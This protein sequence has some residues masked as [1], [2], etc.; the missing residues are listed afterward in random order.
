MRS[1]FDNHSGL[2]QVLKEFP[3][4]L[5]SRPKLPFAQR[6]SRETQNAVVA[7]LVPQIYTHRQTIQ[8]RTHSI[9]LTLFPLCS[10]NNLLIQLLR[11]FR[12][13]LRHHFLGLPLHGGSQL[14][15]PR[16]RFTRLQGIAI[17]LHRSASSSAEIAPLECVDQS[18]LTA[19]T[20][21]GRPSHP[22]YSSRSRLRGFTNKARC[23]GTQVARRP[24][25]NMARTT[26]PRTSG[27]R[28]LA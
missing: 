21:R 9:A 11:Q 10:R 13:Q 15:P 24:S 26:P 19:S 20:D 22:I 17:L 3:N 4:L 18:Q 1:Y 6:L 23:A 2:R 7:P 27:S 25:N 28:G 16:M 5:P 12:N 14:P 8:V